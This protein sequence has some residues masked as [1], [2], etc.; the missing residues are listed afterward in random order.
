MARKIMAIGAHPDDVEF[1]CSGTLV[2]HKA[3][4][5]FVS[6]VCMTDTESTDGTTGELLR[7]LEQNREETLA[8]ASVI[9][10]D[11]VDFLPFKDLH[12]PFSFDSVSMLEKLI[13]KYDIDM[14]YTHWAGDANQD[15]IS[16]FRTTMAA[17]RYVPDV[18]CYEQIPISRM[19]ENQMETTYYVN[20]TDQF[21]TKISASMKHKSQIDKYEKHGLDVKENLETLAKF[22]GIQARCKYA[23]AF[24][25]IKMV[26][27]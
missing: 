17:A 14:I 21:S 13:K 24:H 8:A 3:D 11:F 26:K 2:R 27:S 6:Y 18:V 1:G 7:T 25:I 5:D 15:H 19:S 20:I 9:G 22:R 16:T 12:V 4:G 10:C 23:E